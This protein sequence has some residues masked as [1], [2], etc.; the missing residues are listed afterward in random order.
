M[1]AWIWPR[2]TAYFTGSAQLKLMQTIHSYSQL[3]KRKKIQSQFGRNSFF[4]AKLAWTFLG[5]V[6]ICQLATFQLD[7]H[8]QPLWE[9][10]LTFSSPMLWPS[11]TWGSASRSGQVSQSLTPPTAAHFSVH[12]IE[13]G[14]GHPSLKGL[15]KE[16]W[17]MFLWESFYSEPAASCSPYWSHG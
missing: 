15:L 5:K 2:V 13:E 16:E 12:L 6:R 3:G 9:C 4:P 11:P 10:R 1:P 7:L 8:Q 17:K 14:N